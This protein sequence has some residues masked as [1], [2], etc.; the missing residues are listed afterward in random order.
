MIIELKI[1]LVVDWFVIYV[2]VECVMIEILKVFLKLDLFVVIDFLSD[3][4]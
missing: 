3:E 4:S 2:G 1:V